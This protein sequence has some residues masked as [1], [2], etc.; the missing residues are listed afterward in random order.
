VTTHLSIATEGLSPSIFSHRLFA[1]LGF[2]YSVEVIVTPIPVPPIPPSTP[3]AG[4]RRSTWTYEEPPKYNITFII[5]WDGKV[6]ARSYKHILLDTVVGI[7]VKFKAINIFAS[8][9]GLKIMKTLFETKLNSSKQT[10]I[11]ISVQAKPP[12]FSVKRKI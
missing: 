7:V 6:L 10:P 12:T 9:K 5:R 8:F 11:D 2:G 1:S 3:S 4:G